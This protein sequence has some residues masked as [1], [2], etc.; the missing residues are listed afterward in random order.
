MVD[1]H[2][3]PRLGR[4]LAGA[5][6]YA[7]Y[8]DGAL[9]T[10]FVFTLRG[11]RAEVLNEVVC[12][13]EREIE[14]FAAYVFAQFA[15]AAVVAFTICTPRWPRPPTPMTTTVASGVIFAQERRTAW[16]GVRPAS[17]SGA[18]VAGWGELAEGGAHPGGLAEVA[19][20][21]AAPA[22][23]DDGALPRLGSVPR[24]GAGKGRCGPGKIGLS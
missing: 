22:V 15:E 12:L 14:Q 17:V 3:R 18:A 24:R 4:G 20:L 10:L 19:P 9:R 5:H 13:G 21:A 8:Q 1:D 7:A 2:P 16:Y 11:G 6:T 23:G